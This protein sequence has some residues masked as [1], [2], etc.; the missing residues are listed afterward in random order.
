MKTDKLLQEIQEANLSYLLLAQQMI[1][2]DRA[3]ALYRLGLTEQVADVLE[4]L[5]TAQ[6]LKVASSSMLV[7]RFRFDDQLV[8]DL[9]TSHSK[10]KA[11]AGVHAAILMSSRVAEV[12]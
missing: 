4:S 8:W 7:C 1:R 6:I 12:V 11:I 9:L 2:E 10:D 5:T 3:Q